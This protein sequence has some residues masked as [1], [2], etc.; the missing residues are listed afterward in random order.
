MFIGSPPVVGE[1]GETPATMP[2]AGL[3]TD[4]HFARAE[5][6]GRRGIGSVGG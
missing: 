2:E 4:E 6:G 1:D 5:R 3:V